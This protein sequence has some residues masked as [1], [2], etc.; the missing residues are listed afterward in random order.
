MLNDVE[1]IFHLAAETKDINKMKLVQCQG[2]LNLLNAA[3]RAGVKKWIQLSSV[4][5]YGQS[6]NH[7]VTENTFPNP[8]NEYEKTKLASDEIVIKFCNQNKINFTILRP[9]NVLGPGMK[10]NS[11]FTLVKVIQEKKFFYIGKPGAVAT[12]VHVEDLARALTKS[13]CV[14]EQSIFNLSSDC[15]WEEIIN[16][17]AQIKGVTRPSLRLPEFPFRIACRA[18][19]ILPNLPLS[20]GRLN[21]LTKRWGYPSEKIRKELGFRF[22][23]PM[24]EGINKLEQW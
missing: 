9:S 18:L 15:P 20:E 4:G 6:H 19:K 13:L 16:K 2:T 24:P 14:S 10:K 1:I 8:T 12:Y 3:G 17:I 21:S 11:F 7:N 22:K 23:K 5:V